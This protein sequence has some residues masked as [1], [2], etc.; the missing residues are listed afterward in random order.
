MFAMSPLLSLVALFVF[1]AVGSAQQKV[2]IPEKLERATVVDENGVAQWAEYKGDECPNCVGKGKVKCTTCERYPEDAKF[3]LDCERKPEREAP[4]RMCAGEGK[5]KDPLHT[6]PCPACGAA[7]FLICVLCA[8][9]GEIG[10]AGA[11]KP[12]T[13]PGCSG[14]GGWKCATCDGKRFVEMAAFKPSFADAKDK[15]LQKALTQTDALLK[16]LEDFAP[17]GGPKA[18]KEVKALTKM[19]ES[20]QATFPALKRTIKSTD[21]V[22]NKVYGGSQFQGHEENEANTMKMVAA[23]TAHY[24]KHQKRMLELVHKRAEAN[25]KVD[26]AGKDEKSGK[27]SKGK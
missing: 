22:M 9:R 25:A 20:V 10:V 13:C 19:M 5:L 16:Q 4:C 17:V 23:H 12:T 7:S 24:L 15:D 3:C 26:G 1:A 11:P 2:L 18:R 14:D 8:G 21:D 6:A 27:D